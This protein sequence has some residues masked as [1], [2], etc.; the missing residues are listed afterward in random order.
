MDESGAKQLKC[1]LPCTAL[2]VVKILE[3][4][5]GYDARYRGWMGR[6]NK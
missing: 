4:I 2:S 3:S 1:L 5:G 6:M